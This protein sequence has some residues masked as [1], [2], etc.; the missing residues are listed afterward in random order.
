MAGSYPRTAQQNERKTW[1]RTGSNRL[2]FDKNSARV[3]S[4]NQSKA[5][6]T[7]CNHSEELLMKEASIVRLKNGNSIYVNPADS[8]GKV[9]LNSGGEFNTPSKKTWLHLFEKASWDYIIDIGTNYGEMIAALAPE[10]KTKVLCY[11]ANPELAKHYL[12]RTMQA[13]NNKNI[14]IRNF[15]LGNENDKEVDFYIDMDWSG[16]SGLSRESSLKLHQGRN[17]TKAIKVRLKTLD[18]DVDLSDATALIKIDVEGAELNVIL[19]AIENLNKS[20]YCALMFESLHFSH[21]EILQIKEALPDYD[22]FAFHLG[23][24]SLV[25]IPLTP[26][27]Q[28][29]EFRQLAGIN[30]QDYALIKRH[31]IPSED[32]PGSAAGSVAT[33]QQKRF[34][35]YTALIGGDYENLN[36]APFPKDDN[37][38]YICFT[39]IKGLESES[40]KIVEIS[41]YFKRDNIRSARYLKIMGPLLLG[42]YEASLWIDNS[43][44]LKKPASQIIEE[45]LSDADIALPDHSFRSSIAAEFEAVESS[46]FDDPARIYEQMIAYANSDSACLLEKPFWTAILARRHHESIF[47][48]L[49]KWWSH[50]LRYSRRD[51]LSFNFVAKEEGLHPKRVMI[52]NSNSAYHK[53]P[54]I[55]KRN[56]TLTAEKISSCL[57]IP[58]MDI[59]EMHNELTRR[60]QMI[61][62]LTAELAKKVGRR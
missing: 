30:H 57:R 4:E 16:T 61:K 11:E 6:T 32:A 51:Q 52:D 41:P 27:S 44:S 25:P 24:E 19:G 12:P 48:L 13:L 37:C 35:V 22:L 20:A 58:A 9:L 21:A 10:S 1:M 33:D 47:P 29:D 15:A 50:V 43:V 3:N 40:W 17:T 49:L 42:N 55:E 39:D 62:K 36:R 26:K 34:V 45:W 23:A 14:S 46:G 31:T 5:T 53:W 7:G 56:R 59:G 18:K 2:R 54:A 8:R 28:F 38:D 60:D